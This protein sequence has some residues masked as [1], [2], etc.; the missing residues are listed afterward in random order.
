MQLQGENEETGKAKITRAYNL[1]SKY[2][3]HTVG[4]I[5][6]GGLAPTAQQ[7]EELA[8]C[9][10]ECLD[11]TAERPDISSIAFCCISTGVFGF[12]QMRATDIAIATVKK[13]F[14]EQDA[15]HSTTITHVIFN[16]FKEADEAFYIAALEKL[17]GASIP[18]T[19]S[20]GP[21]LRNNVTTAV[22]W[23]KNSDT[24]LIAAGAGLSA[25]AGLDYT[26]QEVFARLFPAMARK[27]FRCMYEFIGYTD[28]TPQLQWGYVIHNTTITA[29]PQFFDSCLTFTIG[30][31]YTS[32]ISPAT[33]GLNQTYMSNSNG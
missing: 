3:I 22:D 6:E 4:P 12:P 9:Y 23:L 25:A 21:S 5:V 32:F 1:P 8:S 30:I 15:Q 16:V 26:S 18:P 29:T 10:T 20:A 33:P 24:V 11:I 31:C 17:A 28:W 14:E 13:W 19:P 7:D 27:G 2:V